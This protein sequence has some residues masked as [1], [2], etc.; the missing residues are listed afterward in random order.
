M[1]FEKL[2]FHLCNIISFPL[3]TLGFF[4]NGLTYTMQGYRVLTN[5]T[6]ITSFTDHKRNELNEYSN[7]EEHESKNPETDA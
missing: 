4:F 3:Q 2:R 5:E 6:I 7:L 1:F